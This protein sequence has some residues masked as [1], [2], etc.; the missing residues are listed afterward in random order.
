MAKKLWL[1][2]GLLT[3]ALGFTACDDDSDDWPE[4]APREYYV[5]YTIDATSEIPEFDE[6]Y[7]YYSNGQFKDQKELIPLKWERTVGPF[8]NLEKVYVQ[9]FKSRGNPESMKPYLTYKGRLAISTD[10]GKTFV[11]KVVDW[12]NDDYFWMEYEVKKSDFKKQ[13]NN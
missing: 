8:D 1:L 11:D 2:M 12:A 6:V 9:C 10:G 13:K 5:R 3:V 4:K 7:V